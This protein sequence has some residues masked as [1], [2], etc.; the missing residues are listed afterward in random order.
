M[1]DGISGTGATIQPPKSDIGTLS[2]DYSTFLKLLT[3]Q[4]KNQD[5]LEPTD[6][7]EFTNQL[8]SFSQVE[9]QIKTNDNLKNMLAL[10]ALNVTS[11]GLGFIGLEV[12]SFGD[13]AQF[14]GTDGINFG[15][16]VP[17]GTSSVNIKLLDKD[18]SVIYDNAGDA[19]IGKNIFAWNGKGTDGV[20]ATPGSYTI[21]VTLT[22]EDGKQ[23]AATTTA[24][25]TVTGIESDGMG[26]IL[27]LIG[28]EKIP[29][30]DITNARKPGV[31]I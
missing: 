23:T 3:T 22:G 10:N 1:V 29:I 24:P 12:Q 20:V 31:S 17:A 25:G 26:S 6:T 28:D 9:Q 4:L 27:L 30:T 19:A 21:K 13:T 15:Y 7:T 11:L 2:Q 14:N 18:G 8:V 5:P 16:E